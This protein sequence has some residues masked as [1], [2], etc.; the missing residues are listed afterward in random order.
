MQ[1]TL[2]TL[3]VGA[4][5][6]VVGYAEQTRYSARLIRLGLIPGTEL[7]VQRRAPLGDPLE[8]RFRGY[9]LVLRPD[10]ADCLTLEVLEP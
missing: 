4:R 8:I 5:A 2:S 3:D 9:S 7:V 10:E 6:R 1:T